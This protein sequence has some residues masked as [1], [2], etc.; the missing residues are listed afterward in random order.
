MK[1]LKL[2][3]GG[4][5][6]LLV[7]L[8]ALVAV[9]TLRTEREI[10]TFGAAVAERARQA[11]APAVDEA[12]VRKLPAPVQRYFHYVFPDGIPVY[13]LVRLEQAGDF[14]RPL[15]ESFQPTT[16]QQ[17]IAANT[18]A[19][20][21]SATTPILP[22]I[23]ARAYDFFADGKMRMKARI[24]STLTVVD[25]KESAD[26]NAISLRRWLLE[27]ALYPRALLPGGPVRWE[28]VDDISARAVVEQDGLTARLIAHFDETGRMTRMTAESD[29]DLTTPYHGSGE[30]VVRS[31][32]RLVAG[33]M[34][35][36]AF[37]ISRA[38]NG[39]IHPFWSGRIVS[40][41]FE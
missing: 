30:D 33:Q 18:P 28:A 37:T 15:T 1:P 39:K 26:L 8:A 9:Q 4:L 25:Q 10:S 12:A 6:A 35:P 31:D 20:I 34:I 22:G 23:W 19:M 3:G 13:T 14:R 36:M 11:S 24:M 27:S 2:I 41:A 40:I 7:L 16:A 38:A 21:F 32:Y 29:G 17:V 5:V